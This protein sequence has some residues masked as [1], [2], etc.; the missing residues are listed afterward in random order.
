[1]DGIN[2]VLLWLIRFFIDVL[3]A[4]AFQSCLFQL[5]ERG[6]TL[7]SEDIT[8]TVVSGGA[9]IKDI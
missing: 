7:H 2:Y 8:D 1:M 6:R 9:N 3:L 5:K 4:A